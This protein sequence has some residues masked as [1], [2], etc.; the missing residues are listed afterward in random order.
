VV[1]HLDGWRVRIRS[2]PFIDYKGTVEAVDIEKGKVRVLLTFFGRKTS[3]ECDFEQFEHLSD[4]T[5]T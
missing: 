3:V 2:G 4:R 5:K 1:L